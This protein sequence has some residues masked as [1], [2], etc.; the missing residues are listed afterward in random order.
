MKGFI[1]EHTHDGIYEDYVRAGRMAGHKKYADPARISI[2]KHF[3]G[4]PEFNA[5][6]WPVVA[7][8]V[9]FCVGEEAQCR[10]LAERL[11][12]ETDRFLVELEQ[13]RVLE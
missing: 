5:D 4:G 10:Q 9:E 11:A 8:E 13:A 1:R 7:L 2:H 3:P 6:S 12:E